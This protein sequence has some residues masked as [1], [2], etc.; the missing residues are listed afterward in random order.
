MEHLQNFWIVEQIV[1]GGEVDPLRENVDRVLILGIG[2]SYMGARALFDALCDRYH[3]ERSR[4]EREGVPRIYFAGNNFDNDGLGSLL[5]LL[6]IHATNPAEVGD[7]WAVLVASKSGGTLETA[8]A[9]RLVLRAAESYYAGEE[10]MLRQLVVPITGAEGKLRKLAESFGCRDVFTVP[11]GIGGRFSIFTPVALLP[12]A[13]MGLD[14]VALL[15]GAAVM[16]KPF[17]DPPVGENPAPDYVGLA[18][19]MDKKH[20]T[21]RASCRGSA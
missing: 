20:H 8:S 3:N 21:G 7:R 14:V 17:R 2:G 12:A 5:E 4:D 16:T 11:E 9:F 1:Q 6:E 13:V 10:D 15:E 18:H 19:L